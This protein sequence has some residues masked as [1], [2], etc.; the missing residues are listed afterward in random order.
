MRKIL[1]LGL[2]CAGIGIIAAASSC[3]K[4]YNS[5]P[6][7]GQDTTKNSFRGTFTAT[8]DGEAFSAENK[9]ASDKKDDNG[10]RTVTISGVMDSKAKDP[11][12]N[13]SISLSIYDYKGPGFYP[14]QFGTAG[15]YIMLNKGTA[16]S[17][18]AK[19]GDTLAL[20]QI[21][22]DAGTLD[23]TFNF[24]V[25]PGGIGESDNHNINNGAFSVP[26]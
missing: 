19:T 12:T 25:A 4:P 20:I 7:P 8:I 3:S 23:G 13:Q 26:K 18:L 24:V 9:W 17:Y 14:I 21:T 2:V 5:G 16:T 22:N 6:Y 1:Q 10:I 11:S 15:S